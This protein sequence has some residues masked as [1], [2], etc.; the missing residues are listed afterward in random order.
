LI[1]EKAKTVKQYIMERK[2]TYCKTTGYKDSAASAVH[3]RRR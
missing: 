3:M 2:A 1:N